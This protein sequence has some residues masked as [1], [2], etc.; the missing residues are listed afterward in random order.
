MNGAHL[1]AKERLHQYSGGVRYEVVAGMALFTV[2]L[3]TATLDYRQSPDNLAI[4]APAWSLASDGTL[5]VDEYRGVYAWFVENDG[6]VVS[7]RLPGAILWATPFYWVFG[8]GGD[9]APIWPGAVASAAAATLA[10]LFMYGSLRSLACRRTALVASACFGL[11]SP[12]W[13][14]S[15]DGMWTHG[16]AQMLITLS[17]LLYARER[18]AGGGLAQAGAI[19]VRPHLAVVPA[20]MGLW[21][22]FRR[23]SLRP[24]VV[25][26]A[27]SSLGIFSLLLYYRLLYDG[28]TLSGGYGAEGGYDLGERL[29]GRRRFVRN[30]VG[31]FIS[32]GRGIL[33]YTPFLV[34]LLPGLISA[35][36]VA[37]VWVKSAALGAVPYAAVQLWN[38]DFSGGLAGFFPYRLMIE[39]LTLATP[40][41]LLAYETWTRKHRGRFLSFW[42]LTFWTF[43]WHVAGAVTPPVELGQTRDPFD[44]TLYDDVFRSQPLLTSLALTGALVA[45]IVLRS[46]VT[47]DKR[48]EAL[49]LHQPRGGSARHQIAPN[50]NC[51]APSDA[52]ERS[53]ATPDG[54]REGV[55]TPKR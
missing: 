47:T 12:T 31:S 34:L 49:D 4:I 42:A 29:D 11:A 41:L 44:E 28:W 38:N 9:F 32:P 15:A 23:R 8:Q 35:W 20:V 22:G 19:V 53:E 46:R 17:L 55:S 39:P 43:A 6:H 18:L 50:A 30:V 37:P 36:R 2:Y 1:V 3:I 27:T 45:W 10:V 21:E 16:P 40:L 48:V 7:N 52:R 54:G 5:D 25:V 51:V 33:V 24:V 14:V 26:A 13:S